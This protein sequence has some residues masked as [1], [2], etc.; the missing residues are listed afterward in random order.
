LQLFTITY[1]FTH[2]N[3]PLTYPNCM[4]NHK[5]L[6]SAAAMLG[7]LSFSGCT[8]PQMIKKA[9]EQKLTTV[10]SPL[11]VHGEK[12]SF[13]MTAELPVKMLKKG[14]TYTGKVDYKYGEKRV[15]V[16]TIEFKA[17]DFPNAKKEQ[18]K[19]N[20]SFSFPF[21]PDMEQRGS[22]V[23][24]GTAA[25]GSKSK[26][27]PEFPFTPGIITTSRLV[28]NIYLPSYADHGYSNQPE[29]E[30]VNVAFF[31]PQ[32]KSD[33]RATET[34]SSRGKFLD[35]F[36]AEKNV[37]K[38]VTVTGTHSP[39]GSDEKN[40]KVSN[41]RA[42]TV[43]K[44]YKGEMKKYDYKTK[45]DSIEFVQKALVQ[46]WTL[47]K[48]SLNAHKEI[49]QEQKDQALAVVDGSDSFYDKAAQ[50]AKLP[51]YRK[52]FAGVYPKLRTAQT[53]IL[54][55]KDKKTDAEIAVLAKQIAEGRENADKLE[56][57]ELLY[58]AAQTPSLEEKRAIYDAT[59]KKT[60][61]WQA[62]NNLAAV[63]LDLAKK[64][65]D[66]TKMSS[67][68]DGA[69]THLQMANTK[70]ESAEGYSNLAVA[71][72]MK[73]M[74]TEADAALAK[75]SGMNASQDVARAINAS[76]GIAAI[77]KGDYPGAVNALNNAGQDAA[78]LYNKGLAQVLSKQYEP[79]MATLN[80]SATANASSAYTYYV[81][82]IAAA[83]SKNESAMLSNLQKAVSMDAQ[84]KARA[85]QDLEFE[86]SMNS[87]G[88][89]N[90]VK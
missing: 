8:L 38:T 33:L 60:D 69:I 82:A 80:E 17:A 11:E 77:K 46:D 19:L 13:D 57:K 9:K 22:L 52:L 32:G 61:S 34:K 72:N 65:L 58:A 68:V 41:G 14:T 50:L 3:K 88:F 49:P 70:T 78:V 2:Q 18:P 27:T 1:I 75:A 83:R 39:E 79:A 66:K 44:Y 42:G 47:F 20:K 89:K 63:H 40:N 51:F 87:E 71:Y 7:I 26:V 6:L 56:E 85:V 35:A 53:E 86:S 29:F 67:L 23:L 74:V 30:P 37:T 62:H 54:K 24:T 36:I 84:L 81:M 5:H 48:D 28:Q 59:A 73:G 90:A 64:E 16:G 55:M 76:K 12:V 21:T 43:E 31:F 10:P 15:E 45:A 4:R 25:K